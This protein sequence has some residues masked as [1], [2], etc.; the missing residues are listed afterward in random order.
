[1][2]T[3]AHTVLC[4]GGLHRD[5]TL[6]CRQDHV[7]ATSNPVD[8]VIGAGGVARNVA[9][10]L[11]LLGH[12]SGVLSAVGDDAGAQWLIADL[13]ARGVDAS[14]VNRLIDCGTAEYLAILD[15]SGELIAGYADMAIYDAL[16]PRSLEGLVHSMRQFDCWL[17]DANLRAETLNY[18][19]GVAAG[20]ILMATPVSPA[21][22]ARLL[23]L[24]A[25]FDLLVLNHREARAM[26]GLRAD[27]MSGAVAAGL[28]LLSGVARKVIVTLG[29]R[30]ALCFDGR[31]I[32]H[33][34]PP[35]A[36]VQSVNGA[37]DALFAG[38]VS[39]LLHGES[40]QEATARGLACASLSLESTQSVPAKLA[41]GDLAARL[42]TVRGERLQTN[43]R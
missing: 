38:A 5:R 16:S 1:M 32:W 20:R 13:L 43:G 36:A 37:G 19:A 18:L 31:I 30:G 25:R 42:A 34:Q 33:G 22:S 27:T 41:E 26:T 40:L 8:T 28:S 10:M 7:P 29:D 6:H 17:V 12:R 4:V 2:L 14:L 15:R 24:P 3:A 21:K 9:A 23:G 35:H 11:T 39:G